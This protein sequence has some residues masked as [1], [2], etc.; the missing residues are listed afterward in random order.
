LFFCETNT[1]S[2]NF[3][4]LLQRTNWLDQGLKLHH[5]LNQKPKVCFVKHCMLFHKICIV[6]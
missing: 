6:I 3:I 1:I 2:F 4:S 5:N